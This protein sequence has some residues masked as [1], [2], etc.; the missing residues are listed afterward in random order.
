MHA[1]DVYFRAGV[2]EGKEGRNC[3]CRMVLRQEG[4][5]RSECQLPDKGRG[6]GGKRR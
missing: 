1:E 5:A 3:G 4:G 2:R 6:S